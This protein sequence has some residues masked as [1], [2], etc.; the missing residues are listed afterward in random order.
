MTFEADTFSSFWSTV[1]RGD[2]AGDIASMTIVNVQGEPETVTLNGK[3][4]LTS[5]TYDADADS[6]TVDLTEQ[7]I[8]I[9]KEF[10]LDW[11]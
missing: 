6:I 7:N 1:V 5:Y 8:Q 3:T 11:A 9:N 4:Q 10:T 2:V